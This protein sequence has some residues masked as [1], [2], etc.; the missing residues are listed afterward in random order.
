MMTWL[1]VQFRLERKGLFHWLV[2]VSVSL[3]PGFCRTEILRYLR[4]RF[5]DPHFGL[6]P[7]HRLPS[8]RPDLAKIV[9]ESK[10]VTFV[11][12]NVLLGGYRAI[13]RLLLSEM[14][15]NWPGADCGGE[16]RDNPCH[17]LTREA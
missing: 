17:S 6:P 9:R 7:L 13:G 16:V 1:P 8:L 10:C 4:M 11:M 2:V 12:V 5:T 15:K 3:H 14:M